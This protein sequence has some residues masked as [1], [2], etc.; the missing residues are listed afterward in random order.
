[1][2]RLEYYTRQK[3]SWDE[4]ELQEI[5]TEYEDRQLTISQIG[6]IHRRTP[7]Q[8]A[9]ALRRIG[10]VTHNTNARGYFEYYEIELYSEIVSTPKVKSEKVKKEKRDDSELEHQGAKWEH[11]EEQQLLHEIEIGMDH[12][13]IAK[14]HGRTD[15]AIR[16]RI[17]HIVYEQYTKGD[18][19]E[20]IAKCMKLSEHEVTSIINKY[21]NVHKNNRKKKEEK[22]ENK[23]IQTTQTTIQPVSSQPILM[24]A[25]P[26]QAE[27]TLVKTELAELKTEVFAIK[28]MLKHISTLMESI[29]EFE[30]A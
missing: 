10:L 16:K 15:A 22:N 6:D 12:K 21:I 3:E 26:L 9:Y 1:M 4:P 17:R 19:K 8:I 5:R 11:L 20:S 13:T 18:T 25:P 28:K 24:I 27:F 30:S 23:K 7:G 14:N 29:Y 2:N